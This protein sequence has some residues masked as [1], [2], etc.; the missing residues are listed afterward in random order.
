MKSGFRVSLLALGAS[1]IVSTAVSAQAINPTGTA[2][3]RAA[4]Q[5]LSWMD[6]EWVGE[7]TVA[8]GPGPAIAHPHTERIGPMLGGSIKVIEGRSANPDGTAGFNA[9]AIVSWDDEAD[10][11]VMRSYANGQAGDFPLEATA[12]GFRWSTPAQGG[13]MRYV[14]TFTDGQWVEVGAFVMPGR[15]PMKVIELRLRRRGDTNWPAG[16]PVLP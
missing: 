11:Y 2:E 13:E 16:D 1:L 15:E 6:G 5:A 8:M 3:Q 4:M 9:F 10:H 12:D 7:A 14:S